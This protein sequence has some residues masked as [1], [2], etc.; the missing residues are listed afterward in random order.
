MVGK[1]DIGQ[2]VMDPYGRVGILR[3]V[4]ERWV[5]PSASPT[6]MRRTTMAFIGPEKGGGR[7]WEV[8]SSEVITL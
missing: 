5:D 7:E 3:D 2:R 8:P 1:E 6:M 4:I